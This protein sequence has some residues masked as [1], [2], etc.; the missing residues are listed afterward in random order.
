MD[1]HAKNEF[2]ANFVLSESGSWSIEMES[3]KHLKW[4]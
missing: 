1:E 2:E 3:D 4:F